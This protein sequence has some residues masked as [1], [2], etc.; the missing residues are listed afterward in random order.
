MTATNHALTG[1]VIALVVKKPELAIPLAFLSHFAVDVIP[2]FEAREL[3]PK[4]SKAFIF[5]DAIVAGNL[6]IL[7][8]VL[9]RNS[10]SIW[11]ISA[12][13]FAAVS[14]DL[15]WGWRYYRIKDL[16]KVFSEPM[17]WL[18]RLHLK[19][20]LSE[21]LAGIIV[22]VAWLTGMVFLIIELG[23]G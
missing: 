12:C 4:F 13:M 10:L 5:G 14:P 8:A 21:T 19:I 15:M 3:P 18:S 9:L 1:A 16:D 23:R 22:E 2:H 7:L 20:Q 11:I 17:S 6:A